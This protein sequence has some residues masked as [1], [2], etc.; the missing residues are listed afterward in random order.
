[1]ILQR[2]FI[3]DQ[4]FTLEHMA[5]VYQMA[6]AYIDTSISEAASLPVLEAMASGI[7]VCICFN[8]HPISSHLNGHSSS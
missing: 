6:D 4:D 5:E 1:L 7:P 8:F 2:L 3:F